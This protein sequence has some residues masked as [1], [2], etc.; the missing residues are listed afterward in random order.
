MANEVARFV[1]HTLQAPRELWEQVS[2]RAELRCMTISELIR[3]SLRLFLVVDEAI[4]PDPTTGAVSQIIIRRPD[5][6][7]SPIIF[8]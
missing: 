8:L 1:K 6:T 7:E 5:G 2:A 3:K 4:Q